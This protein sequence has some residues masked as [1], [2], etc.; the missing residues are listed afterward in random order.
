M[1]VS[2]TR[3]FYILSLVLLGVLLV[4]TV[5]RP[6]ITVGQYSE[7]LREGLIQSEN[8]WIFQC[9]ILNNEGKDTIYTIEIIVNGKLYDQTIRIREGARFTYTHHVLRSTIEEGNV[10]F[11]IYKEGEDTPFEQTT[12]Y[13]Q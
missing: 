13:L 2:K 5:F 12:Y 4:F 8:G 9:V 1:T 7:V 11:N 10:S 3:V 6:F